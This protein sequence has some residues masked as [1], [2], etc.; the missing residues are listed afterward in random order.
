ML[1]IAL[2]DADALNVR[3]LAADPYGRFVRS[4]N[5]LP[6][7]VH[8]GADKLS[9]TSDDQLVEENFVTPV[10]TTGEGAHLSSLHRIGR[11]TPGAP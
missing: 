4:P 10:N 7:M 1:G 2:R 9:N 8:V 6:H 3:L 11:R 5:G